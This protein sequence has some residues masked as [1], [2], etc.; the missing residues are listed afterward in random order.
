M[1]IQYIPCKQNLVSHAAINS[2]LYLSYAIVLL[3]CI[4]AVMTRVV[5]MPFRLINSFH[6]HGSSYIFFCYQDHPIA[7][8]STSVIYAN[9][10]SEWIEVMDTIINAQ[11]MCSMCMPSVITTPLCM[12]FLIDL[13]APCCVCPTPHSPILAIKILLILILQ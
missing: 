10:W 11:I 6:C 3:H 2:Y 8:L 4:D 7:T 9:T 12:K 13:A 1:M 5:C